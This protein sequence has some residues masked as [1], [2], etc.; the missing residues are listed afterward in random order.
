VSV[1]SDRSALADGRSRSSAAHLRA[2]KLAFSTEQNADLLLAAA[3]AAPV[4]RH[5]CGVDEPSADVPEDG[6]IGTW[7]ELKRIREAYEVIAPKW[8]P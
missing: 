7:V 1:S 6:S 5:L 8:H 3:T 4:I 2:R